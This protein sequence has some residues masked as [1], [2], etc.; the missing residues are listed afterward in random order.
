MAQIT[1]REYALTGSFG[2]GPAIATLA[3]RLLALLGD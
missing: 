3:S 1:A 2:F